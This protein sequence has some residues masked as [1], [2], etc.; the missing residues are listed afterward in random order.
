MSDS[1]IFEKLLGVNKE[2]YEFVDEIGSGSF[3]RI[4]RAEDT[5]TDTE[6]ILKIIEKEKLE[7]GPKDYLVGQIENEI[8]ILEF[9]KN[10]SENIIQLLDHFE[11]ELSSV[12]IF[13]NFKTDLKKYIHSDGPFIEKDNSE[14]KEMFSGIINGLSFLYDN[15]IIH[16]DI[17]PANIYLQEIDS[18]LIPKIADFGVA[19]FE[20]ENKKDLVGTFAYMAPEVMK[21]SDYD[22]ECDMWSIG[23]T[24]YEIVM[25]H[26]PYG[27]F[28]S[29]KQ[30]KTFFSKN[31]FYFNLSKN[32]QLDI[33]FRRLLAIDPKKRMTFPELKEYI[34]SPD[35]LKEDIK[36]INNEKKYEEVYNDIN[37]NIKKYNE[38]KQNKRLGYECVSA[39]E[40][41]KEQQINNI[42]Q[43][44]DLDD[45]PN[46]TNNY[47]DMDEDINNIIY[48]D[49]NVND[50]TFKESIYGDCEDFEHET[51]GAFI[52][53]T[54]I[55]SL[56]YIMK[57]INKT[58]EKD[59]RII[60]NLIV[61]GESCD[62]VIKNLKNNNYYKLI[63]NICIFC[64]DEQKHINKRGRDKIVG[65]YTD[66]KIIIDE[67]IKKHASK[68]I[69]PFFITKLL[70][71]KEY[72]EKYHSRHEKIA[73][74]YGEFDKKLYD[75]AINNIYAYI[76]KEKNENG[77]KIPTQDEDDLIE[78]F[79]TFDKKNDFDDIELFNK[80]LI[81]EY[82]KNTF[83]PDLNRWLLSLN[84]NS[85]EYIAYFT[86]RLMYCLSSYASN[87]KKYYKINNTVRR[88]ITLPYSCIQLYERAKD[89]IIILPN[90]TSTTIEEVGEKGEIYEDGVL[91]QFSNRGN[92]KLIKLVYDKN[93]VFSVIVYIENVYKEDW[94]MNGVD[95]ID[96]SNSKDE[97]EILYLPFSFYYVK[98]VKV[99]LENKIAD[100]YLRTCGKKEVIEEKIKQG[101][102]VI[103]L[104]ENNE[105]IVVAINT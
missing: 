6:V 55:E 45:I 12:L 3:S 85:Y 63:K 66:P 83:Y 8:K 23:I 78:S 103:V 18:K 64:S 17:K 89:K 4:Y 9:C 35:F 41:S 24:L 15:K 34:F 59:N 77:L 32:T 95:I 62:N 10:K 68:N 97:E 73:K 19:T 30:L 47:F 33:L 56:N 96:V 48:Y 99:D 2:K 37:K 31:I 11:T 13:E 43:Y 50:S 49:E 14:I 5:E 22:I 79:K 87:E 91:A 105:N 7:N 38:F 39:E 82:T 16:R 21:Q 72:K 44:I 51:N 54:N 42:I 25:G 93:L 70:T 20:S 101:K 46:I 86:G 88:G 1:E 104:K 40:L 67:F 75:E 94:I 65:V 36:F 71:Y 74:Y 57:E 28:V 100:I 26:M 60:F 52:F 80:E 84:K 92:P 69:K 90:F 29:K 61:T 53:C 27:K 76:L 102:E 81:K 58:N 98:D